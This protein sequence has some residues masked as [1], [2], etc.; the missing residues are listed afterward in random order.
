M[1]TQI[2][3]FGIN[4]LFSWT[5]DGA[6]TDK[7]V[8]KCGKVSGAYTISQETTLAAAGALAATLPSTPVIANEK[9][10]LW[11]TFPMT[12]PFFV[13]V[14]AC[15]TIAG[16]SSSVAVNVGNKPSVP[17]FVSARPVP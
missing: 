9:K 8:V 13:Q 6:D 16:C 17:L 14:D 3:L 10:L 5:S 11:N 2:L 12:Y 7:F 15:N 1:I 4:L